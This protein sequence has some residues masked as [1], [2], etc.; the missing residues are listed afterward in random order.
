MGLT[1][2]LFRELPK[3]KDLGFLLQRPD[4]FLS[5]LFPEPTI[6]TGVNSRCP[7]GILKL[8][9]QGSF[10]VMNLITPIKFYTQKAN[11]F[12]VKPYILCMSKNK[13]QKK[14]CSCFFYTL[15]VKTFSSR[16]FKDNLYPKPKGLGF[17]LSGIYNI[18]SLKIL[19][20]FN[21]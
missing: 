9:L 19:F 4:N 2:N 15:I 10:E 16:F 3:S 18:T 8:I 14:R 5:W 17:R 11:A 7:N 20:C 6:S 1:Q 13:N 12:S 21:S